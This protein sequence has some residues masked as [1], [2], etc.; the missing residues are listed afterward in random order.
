MRVPKRLQVEETVSDKAASK[1]KQA[2]DKQ[3]FQFRKPGGKYNSI[4]S[5][6]GGVRLWNGA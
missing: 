4:A 2:L 3:V 5:G 6:G 1:G